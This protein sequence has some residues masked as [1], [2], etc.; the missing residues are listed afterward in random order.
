MAQTRPSNNAAGNKHELDD[1]SSGSTYRPSKAQKK[2]HSSDVEEKM[3][4]LTLDESLN[5]SVP[6]V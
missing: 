6:L 5:V 1:R 2:N 4:H 3:K